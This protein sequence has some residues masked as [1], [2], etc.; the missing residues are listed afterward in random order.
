M[1]S[2]IL[3]ERYAREAEYDSIVS[4]EAMVP[5]RD[6]V[7]LATDI[8]LPAK[9][10]TPVEGKFPALLERT[11]YSTRGPRVA[12]EGKIPPF[13]EKTHYGLGVSIV[14]S[15]AEPEFFAKRGYAVILQNVRGRYG[16]EGEFYPYVNDGRDG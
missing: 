3:L 10:G 11:P 5:M 15:S 7:R 16:S 6:G 13:F 1:T 14:P 2:I 9:N 4:S 12:P 8:Y